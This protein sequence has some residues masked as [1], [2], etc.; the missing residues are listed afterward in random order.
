VDPVTEARI[1]AGFNESFEA[2]LRNPMPP[3]T[4]EGLSKMLIGDDS[5]G[6]LPDDTLPHDE[7]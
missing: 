3:L 7:T 4:G 5:D 2:A 6:E 1:R